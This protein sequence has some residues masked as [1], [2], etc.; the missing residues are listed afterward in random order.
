MYGVTVTEPPLSRAEFDAIYQRVP[1]LTVEV[2]VRTGDGVVLTRRAIPPCQGQ[3]HIPGGT[4]WFGETLPAAV[5]RV[6]RHELGVEVQIHR[7]LGYIEYP[8]MAAE[9]Y[10]GWPIGIAF[11]VG[12]VGGTVHAG[13][14]TEEVGVFRAVPPN[15]ISEQEEFLNR[16]V[17]RS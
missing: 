14:H 9:G 16:H 5:Y 3:W 10:R 13:D 1:R 7:L 4:V 17:F 6:A 8:K 11:E 15:T 2:V 12:I